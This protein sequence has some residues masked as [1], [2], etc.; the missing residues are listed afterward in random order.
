MQQVKLLHTLLEKSRAIGHK[1]RQDSLLNSVESVLR[2]SKLSLTSLGRGMQKEIKPKS[3]IQQADYLLSNG[4]LHSERLAIYKAINHWMIG[5]QE[6]IL[7]ILIDWSVL[8]HNQGYLLRASLVR[9]KGCLTVYEDIYPEKQLGTGVA[10]ADFL[11]KLKLVLPPEKKVCLIVD[12]GFRTDFFIQVKAES[13]DYLGRILSNMHYTPEGKNRW[14]PCSELYAE[15]TETPKDIGAVNLSKATK[16]ESHLYLYKKKIEDSIEG[17]KVEIK[18]VKCGNSEKEYR[19]SAK[20]PWLIASSFDISAEK[21]M[22][23]YSKRMQIEHDFRDIKD[24][25]WGLGIRLSRSKDI[26][27]LGILLLIGFLARFLLWLTGLCLEEKKMHFDF[28]AN[29]VKNKRVLSLVF[30]A[31]EAIKTRSKRYNI[32]IKEMKQQQACGFYDPSLVGH[33]L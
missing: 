16:I 8:G 28:Q 24:P 12:A 26:D 30:L 7:Y 2:G 11:Q 9:K 31:L 1:K 27:R 23:L 33:F 22:K 25:K 21:I 3:K 4:Q 13:W 5:A 19:N 15:A 10:H 6:N 20:K 18:R 29:T 17:T 14:S 32:P